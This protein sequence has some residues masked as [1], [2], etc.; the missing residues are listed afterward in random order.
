MQEQNMNLS[1]NVES[2]LAAFPALMRKTYLWMTLG[3]VMTALAA[4]YVAGNK[5]LLYTI[6]SNQILFFGLIIGELVLVG[7]LSARIMRMSFLTAGLLFA[8]YSILNGVT[9]SAILV[10]YKPEVIATTFF[11]T[12][13]TFAAMSLVGF[14]IKKDISAVGK[15][16]FM[17]L[18]GII[19]AS[20]VNIFMH[21]E[22]LYYA[23]T[24][25]G[26]LVFAG[27]TAYDTQKIK[28]MFLAYGSE[29]NE[30]TQKLALLGSLTL[31]LDFINLFLFLLRIFGDHE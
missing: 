28:M 11:V 20:I 2:K 29:V 9:L 18:I 7:V 23:I 22:A 25:I 19:I 13:G 3:L 12:A 24:Y 21:S 16:M 27:L 4:Y 6:Y 1:Y 17:A 14:F 8:G 31:Y 15:F 5:E 30:E 26:V 10:V